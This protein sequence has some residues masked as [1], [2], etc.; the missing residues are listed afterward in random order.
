MK[1]ILLFVFS[2]FAMTSY[3]FAGEGFNGQDVVAISTGWG[4]EGVYVKTAVENISKEGCGPGL[5]ID[6]A[7]PFL[8][9]M[10][11]M[12]LMA[13]QAGKK[14]D[15]YVEGCYNPLTINLKAVSIWK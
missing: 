11:A 1:N 3:C 4:S 13:Q 12:L 5:M 2:L 8:K 14:V 9:T 7:H 10:V 6:P 15:L